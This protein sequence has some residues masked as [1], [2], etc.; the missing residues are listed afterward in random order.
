MNH[1]PQEGPNTGEKVAWLGMPAA[2]AVVY[3]S[4]LARVRRLS[5]LAVSQSVLC[6]AFRK[7]TSLNTY[8]V[9]S[10]KHHKYEV[11]IRQIRQL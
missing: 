9:S 1:E 10:Y 11:R 4:L 6:E 8:I 3:Q 5:C 2:R 7:S